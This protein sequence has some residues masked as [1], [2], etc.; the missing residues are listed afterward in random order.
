MANFMFI[1]DPATGRSGPLCIRV[2]SYTQDQ[3]V[4]SRQ[5]R[6]VPSF[7]MA[8][9]RVNA[10]SWTVNQ[11]ADWLRASKAPE[12][13]VAAF[14][15]EDI[16]GSALRELSCE[17][18]KLLVPALTLGARLRLERQLSELRTF[19][20]DAERHRE[21]V[22]AGEYR[23]HIEDVNVKVRTRTGARTRRLTP[24]CR[25]R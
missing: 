22:D 16:D 24:N 4:G 3:A 14:A 17:E 11:V 9:P 7:N 6:V 20:D 10:F 2:G 5:L 13:V 1:W 8:D 12:E 18:L 15:R 19:V 25:C 23:F 21:V